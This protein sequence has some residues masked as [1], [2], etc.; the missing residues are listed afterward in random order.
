MPAYADAEVEAPTPSVEEPAIADDA[1][2][3]TFYETMNAENMR[4]V[5]QSPFQKLIYFY[6][7]DQMEKA[8]VAEQAVKLKNAAGVV[9]F[10]LDMKRDGEEFLKYLNER[11]PKTANTQKE[12][13][14]V[15]HVLMANSFEDIWFHHK[16]N[17][18]YLYGDFAEQ[19]INFFKGP[20]SL[21]YPEQLILN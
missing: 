17:L 20:Q 12:Q 11:N 19:I 7:G 18:N 14:E 8:Q 4:E 21:Q 10:V 6:R 2:E 9:P 5:M 3:E 13:I 1:E 15:N 16:D